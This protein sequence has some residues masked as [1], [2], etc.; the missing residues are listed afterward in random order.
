VAWLAGASKVALA[1][2]PKTGGTALGSIIQTQ[3]RDDPGYYFSF[4]GLDASKGANRIIVERM[5]RG[6]AAHRAL[7]ANEH[8][9]A[10]GVIVGHFSYD[11]AGVLEGFGLRF[12]AVLREP[13][14]RWISLVWQYTADLPGRRRFGDFEVPSKS[15]DP[16]AYWAAM[17]RIFADHRGGPIPGL[18]PHESMMLCNGMCRVIGGTPLHT[19]DASPDFERVLA[20]LP[21][22]ELALFERFN[23]SCDA[24]LERLGVPVRLDADT[25]P[26]GEE[27]PSGH[28]RH[29]RR[30]GAPAKVV[31]LARALNGDDLRLYEVVERRV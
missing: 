21:A 11:L 9:L 18:M 27:N 30:Y 12:A 13:V 7:L 24:M 25:N 8:F 2:I 31:E 15:G 20:N 4:F 22:F 19:F 23:E 26:R 14:D 16:E 5:R 29:A 3:T 1:H 6:D 28:M 10:S 17:Y